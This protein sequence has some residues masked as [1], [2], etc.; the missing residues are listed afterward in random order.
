M[1]NHYSSSYIITYIH[2][3]R[4]LNVLKHNINQLLKN[5]KIEIIVVEAGKNPMI[6]NLDLKSKYVFAETNV[7]NVGWLFNLGARKATTKHLFFGDN[8]ILPNMDFI[9]NIINQPTGHECVYAQTEIIELDQTTTDNKQY[10]YDLPSKKSIIGGLCY[11]TFDGFYK[12]GMWDENIY[13]KDLYSFQ[14]KKNHLLIKLGKS[15]NTKGIKF[16]LDSARISDDIKEN[17]NKYFD[18]V[19]KLDETKLITYI[20]SQQKKSANIYKYKS[21][22]IMKP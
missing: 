6:K 4:N 10:N 19:S 7:Y 9:I 16:L 5:P 11:Y 14:D 2:S 1:K 15:E 20:R 13:D 18:K 22:E 12:V 8:S 17:S 21:T 3:K